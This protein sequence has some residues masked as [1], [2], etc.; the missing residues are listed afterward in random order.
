MIEDLFDDASTQRPRVVLLFNEPVLALDHPDAE[1]EHEI[2]YTVDAVHETLAKAGY[3]VE[4][5]CVGR[6]P[7][8]L[9]AGL[10]HLLPDVVFNLFEGLA[11]FGGS[12]AHVAGLL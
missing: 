11:D 7:H 8:A 5:L 4:R 6:D 10:R 9:T 12:E 2:L 1:S 3:D